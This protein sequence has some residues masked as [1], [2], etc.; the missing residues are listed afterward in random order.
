MPDEYDLGVLKQ[1][2]WRLTVVGKIYD[3]FQSFTVQN[4][5]ESVAFLGEKNNN[6]AFN[7]FSYIYND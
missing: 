7:S 3:E 4:N 6:T 5:T 2:T 1:S